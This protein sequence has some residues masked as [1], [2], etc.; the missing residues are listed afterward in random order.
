MSH[1]PSHRKD[2]HLLKGILNPGKNDV[3]FGRGG[4]LYCLKL[5]SSSRLSLSGNI[6]TELSH[7]TGAINSHVGN[8]MFRKIVDEQRPFYFAASK[9]DKPLVALRVVQVRYVIL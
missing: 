1:Q 6:A 5:F 8:I 7:P 4:E 9:S 3:L 2:Q